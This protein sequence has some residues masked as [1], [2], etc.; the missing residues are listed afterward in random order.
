MP[1]TEAEQ[2]AELLKSAKTIA[3]VGLSNNPLRAS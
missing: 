3:V 1:V 2:I